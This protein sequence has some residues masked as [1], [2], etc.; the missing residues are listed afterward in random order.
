MSESTRKYIDTLGN[1][2]K[3]IPE[4]PYCIVEELKDEEKISL[5]KTQLKNW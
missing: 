4:L 2:S 1:L 3:P 5:I